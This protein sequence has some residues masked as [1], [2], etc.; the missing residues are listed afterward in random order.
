LRIAVIGAGISGIAAAKTLM[1]F[2]H[3]PVL[4]ERS[5]EIGGVWALAYPQVRLQNIGDHYRFTDF[6]WPFAHDQH[7]TADQVMRY[8]KAAVEHYRLDV[9]RNHNVVALTEASDGWT[10]ELDT[11]EGH[12]SERFDYVIVAAGHYTHEKPEIPLPGRDTFKGKV[13]T[14]RDVT[15]LSIFD[16][17]RVAVMGFGKSAVDMAV[18]A[19]DRAQQVDHIFR[20]PRWLLPRKMLGRHI[21]YV[22]SS[23]DATMFNSS[24]VYPTKWE[25]DMHRRSPMT[26]K[27]YAAVVGYLV[28]MHTGMSRPRRDA[29]AKARMQLVTPKE[30]V[31][32][33]L[34]G[35]LAP[36]SYYPSVASGR[37]EPHKASI[38][39][40]TEDAVQ[41]SDGSSVP[42]DVLVLAVGYKTP[43][44]PFL[45]E[46]FRAA[47][48][49]NDDGVQLYRHVLYPR[50]QRLAFAGFNH[51][52]FHIPGVEVAMTWLGAVLAGDIVLPSA[53]TMDESTA[54]VAAWKRA[55]TIFEPTRAYWVSTR[56]HQYLDVLL[57]ELG[58]KPHR[59]GNP[60][61]EFFGAYS[62]ADYAGVFDEYRAART[63]RPRATLPLDT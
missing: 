1:K 62:P 33:Q 15:D 49:C 40:L 50:L 61:S 8:I 43:E 10:V 9:R 23:R 52:P 25:A 26:A 2:G 56:F 51:N 20:E 57:L 30:S 45:P 5:A 60:L 37:I 42:C 18:F 32:Q 17:K 46:A 59:K 54:K 55:N 3:E 28:K 31:N 63:G 41:L 22:S 12:T 34:R 19:A 36:D 35:T 21:A 16:G 7:P 47:V 27:S 58:V 4:F 48:A 29:R 38:T 24:W 39:G 6:D 13:V 44:M 11:P 14:E 53:E